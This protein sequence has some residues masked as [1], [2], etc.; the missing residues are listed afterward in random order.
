MAEFDPLVAF[1]LAVSGAYGV[2]M[3]VESPSQFACT[4][5]SL[6][7]RKIVAQ[8]AEDDLRD[9]LLADRHFAGARKPELHGGNM[10][11]QVLSSQLSVLSQFRGDGEAH[12]QTQETVDCMATASFAN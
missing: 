10:V 11:E 5:Q 7:G 3:Q 8:N 4:R 1:E 6:P 12:L 9:Q 2:G